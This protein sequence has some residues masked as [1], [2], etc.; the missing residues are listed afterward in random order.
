MPERE[1]KA[2]GSNSNYPYLENINFWANHLRMFNFSSQNKESLAI[3]DP[4]KKAY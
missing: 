2:D 3:K 4:T 1:L